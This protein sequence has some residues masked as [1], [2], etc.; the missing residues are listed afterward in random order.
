MSYIP[1]EKFGRDHWSMLGYME[2]VMVEC[3][4]FQIGYDPRVRSNRTHWRVMREQCPKPLRPMKAPD[5]GY[6]PMKP[7]H[8]TRLIDGTTAENF[9]DD[10]CCVQ[11]MAKTGLLMLKGETQACSV[12]DIEPRVFVVLTP[13]G[14][15]IAAQLRQHKMK[16]GVFATFCPTITTASAA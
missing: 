8:A 12:E 11:D 9:H 16:G 10:W 3:A 6:Q 14:E 4:G 2:T 1:I 7:E 13:L 15:Q 5:L